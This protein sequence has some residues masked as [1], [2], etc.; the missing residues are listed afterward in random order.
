MG[1]WHWL[2][3]KRSKRSPFIRIPKDVLDQLEGMKGLYV[4]VTDE[5]E[6]FEK[7]L[8]AVR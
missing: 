3:V 1:V 7:L 4:V 6:K 2:T 8:E 5:R